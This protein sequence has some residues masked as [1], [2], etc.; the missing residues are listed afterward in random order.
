M[1]DMQPA[2]A[3]LQTLPLRLPDMQRLR[4][5]QRGTGSFETGV[6]RA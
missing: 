3:R 6:Q 5:L 4:Q 1:T 2:D